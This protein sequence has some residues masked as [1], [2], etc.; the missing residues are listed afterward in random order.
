ML[1]SLA[2]ASGEPSVYFPTSS[3][4]SPYPPLENLQAASLLSRALVYS[5]RTEPQLAE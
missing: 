2:V 1:K 4:I 5:Q 3:E